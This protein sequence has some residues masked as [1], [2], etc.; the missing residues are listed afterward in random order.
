MLTTSDLRIIHFAPI[1]PDVIISEIWVGEE[2][3]IAELIWGFDRSK[4]IHLSKGEGADLDAKEFANVLAEQIDALD[5]WADGLRKPGAAW[6]PENPY[7]HN[8]QSPGS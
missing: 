3:I 4:M 2:R 7:Y 8:A 1:E 5:K 6:D